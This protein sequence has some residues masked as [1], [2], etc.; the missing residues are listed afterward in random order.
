MIS[1]LVLTSHRLGKAMICLL[2]FEKW[3]SHDDKGKSFQWND[4]WTQAWSS[5]V[6]GQRF[7]GRLTHDPLS[8]SACG[9]KYY[10][11]LFSAAQTPSEKKKKKLRMMPGLLLLTHMQ[12][13]KILNP[14]ENCFSMQGL[15]SL[16]CL[17]LPP[18][19]HSQNSMETKQQFGWNKI[20]K[21]S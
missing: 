8:P 2:L 9:I 6:K 13:I 16:L 18:I 3:M 11:Q 17:S 15:Q 10:Q 1:V 21:V 12:T 14:Y 4:T 5:Q 19:I 20:K 7:L